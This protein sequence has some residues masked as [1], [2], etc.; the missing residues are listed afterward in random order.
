MLSGVDRR[1]PSKAALFASALALLTAAAV[2]AIADTPQ[3]ARGSKPTAPQRFL[4]SGLAPTLQRAGNGFVRVRIA[5]TT[6]PVGA[7]AAK[8]RLSA[9]LRARVSQADQRLLR[10]V[11]GAGRR[12]ARRQE[13]AREAA[14]EQ[15]AR[16]ARAA[17]AEQRPLWRAVSAVGGR[18]LAGDPLTNTIVALVP[19]GLLRA[20]AARSDV[21]AIEPAPLLRHRAATGLGLSTAAVGAP[22]WSS[23]GFTGGTGPSDAS[24]VDLA[25][26]GDEIQ[27]DHP[28]FAGIT[29]QNPPGS[30]PS[31]IDHGTAVASIAVSRGASGC[32]KCVPDDA[33]R[34]G[35]APGVDT[36]L[37]ASLIYGNPYVWALGITQT[38]NTDGDQ[39][40]G[41][42]DPAEVINN[43]HGTSAAADDDMGLQIDDIIV[44]SLGTTIAYPAGN[45]GPARSVETPCIA[46]NSLCMGAYR[47][48]GTE[49]PADDVVADFSSRGPSPGGRKKPDMVAIGITSYAERRWADSTKGLW[50]ASMDG[51]SWA[52]PQA[53][54]AAALLAGSG[55]SDPA[56]QKAIL[57][58]SSR[59]GRATPTDPMGTQTGWQPDW[60]WG[61]LNLAGALTERANGAASSVPGGSARFYRASSVGAADRATLVWH[62]RATA[63]CLTGQCMALTMTLTNLDLQQLDPA[64]GAVVAQSNSPI[65][66]VEQIRSP[67][68]AATAIYKVKATSTV[69]GLA[70]EPFA[71]SAARQLTP[72]V[73]P[74]PVVTVDVAAGVQRAGDEATVT[75]T[76]R[77]ASP[78]LTGEDAGV[79]LQLPEG[80][81]LV[82][83]AQ[84]RSLGTLGTSSPAQTFTWTVRGTTDGIKGITARAQASRYGETFAS[85]ATDS[86]TVDAAGPSPTI[87]APQGTT[88]E[89]A[90]AV[91]WGAT[92]AHS[93][94]DGY[95]V[96]T[97]TDGQPWSTWLAGTSLTQATYSGL[98][99]HRYRFRVR[100]TDSLGNVS[101]W[102]E[103]GETAIADQQP[104]HRPPGG[105][106]TGST[107]A[108]SD[109]SVGLSRVRRTRAGI[110]V[111]GSIAAAASG[112]VTVTY[113]TK[114]GRKTYRSRLFVRVRSGRFKAT[115]DLPARARNARRG[116]VEIKYRGDA[117]FAP[118]TIKRTVTTR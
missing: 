54:G 30:D 31:G 17:T 78:D 97:S 63:A 11:P 103:S 91:A 39:L 104:E 36:V 116:T 55:I 48:L 69:D 86:F 20:L 106:T 105:G 35:V 27:Q 18:V 85:T 46:Y 57:V 89:R 7:A 99:G 16:P 59:L 70:A 6:D 100:A 58:N 5:L 82:A 33:E 102:L 29:F 53:A 61:A 9:R 108:K 83:G 42:S 4:A 28:A 45:S 71:I 49:D 62:R 34:K 90:L 38:L 66:N 8:P 43:S 77:N 110:T 44:S 13:A 84:A 2:P 15:L 23:A 98:A 76:V 52:A 117:A 96:Q 72:L 109:P 115:L 12:V 50:S 114:I 37:D 118:Q 93:G 3:Q 88:V 81:E 112:G 47:H 10:R 113:A 92:D 79:A 94:I 107:P 1:R 67:G 111:N 73:T 26:A 101:A 41:V 74:E 75:A 14:I 32:P 68:V 22:S 80:V 51:T 87:A 19:R 64:T 95:D 56:M 21:R 25:I 65:D 40:V 60:G 24:P